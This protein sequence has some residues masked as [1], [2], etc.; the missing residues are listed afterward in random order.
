MIKSSP[1]F[2]K[3]FVLLKVDSLLLLYVANLPE[4]EGVEE[5][6]TATVVGM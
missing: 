2:I 4:M 1:Q 6:T 3:H 5:A